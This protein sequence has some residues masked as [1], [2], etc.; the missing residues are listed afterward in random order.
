ME[1]RLFLAVCLV[2]AC[3][4]TGLPLP[5]M[6]DQAIASCR[7]DAPVDRTAVVF[8]ATTGGQLVFVRGDGSHSVAHTFAA[9]AARGAQVVGNQVSTRGDFIAAAASWS[10]NGSFAGAELVLL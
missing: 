9:G 4:R 2:A 6:T 3:N 5:A 10:V 8:A 1:R 7:F